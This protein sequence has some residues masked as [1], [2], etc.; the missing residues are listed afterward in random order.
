[1]RNMPYLPVLTLALMLG[2]IAVVA[3]R[4]AGNTDG[5][6]QA[7][8]PELHGRQAY[9]LARHG[10]YRFPGPIEPDGQQVA[11]AGPY[12][13]Q[14]PGYSAYVAAIFLS[15]PQFPNLTWPCIRDASC[16]AGSGLRRRARAVTAVVRGVT[17]GAVVLAAFALIGRLTLT[18]LAGVLCLILLQR[19][20]PTLL[21]G[22][23]LLTHAGLRQ[24][25]GLGRVS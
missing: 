16:P 21:A 4:C 23:L 9:H 19:D 14:P 10:E 25:R 6:P 22:L 15:V 1:M 20:T 12:S 7:A 5:L 18:A 3:S 17:V 13:S 24:R 11:A 2:G 8:D